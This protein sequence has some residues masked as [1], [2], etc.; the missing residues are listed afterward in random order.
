MK[1]LSASLSKNWQ[2]I[3]LALL[4]LIA[5]VLRFYNISK[6]DFFTY[7][8]ARDALYTKR[9]VADHKFTLIGPQ[10]SIPGLYTPPLY[11]YMMAPF[12]R[13]FNFNPTALDF[14]TA[15]L[16][17]LTVVFLYY[18]LRLLGANS[19]ISLA[20]TALYAFQPA[21]VYQSRYAW[22]PNTIPFFVLLTLLALLK[23]MQKKSR[24]FFSFLFWGSLGMVI[25]LH[26]SGVVFLLACLLALFF[27]RKEIEIKKLIFGLPLFVFEL[28]PLLIFDLR[29]SFSNSKAVINYFFNSPRS[30]VATSPFIVGLFEKARFLFGLVFP[31]SL[32]N[33]VLN[34]LLVL[35]IFI[36][37]RLAWKK[38]DKNYNTLLLLLFSSLI[39]ASLY[40]SV[41]YFFYLTFLYPLPFL[42]VGKAVS[43]IKLRILYLAIAILLSFSALSWLGLS[44][45]QVR[46]DRNDLKEQLSGTALFLS[47]K[48][49]APFNLVSINNTSERF[50]NNA[51]DYRYFLETFYGKRS[52]DWDPAG[53]K[54]SQNLYLI[55]EIGRVDPLK[56]SIWEM[57]L[58]APKEVKEKWQIGDTIIYH[59]VK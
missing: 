35:I 31:I 23:L 4:V 59:L 24:L 26:Y 30:E 16:G 20:M 34:I 54:E 25:N 41:F 10:S 36:L 42:L 9:I 50:G 40:K 56:T 48:V 45:N 6:L 38:K 7:D 53:Y 17:V 57:S 39:F 18:V 47:E 33:L 27:C 19:G 49:I 11:Y 46:K 37:I 51:V 14:V 21:I 29:H 5:A 22:N 1:K 52:L 55:S 13:A 15:T 3:V 28:S 43:L 8:Q 2:I 32:N 58:F 12:L 44:L